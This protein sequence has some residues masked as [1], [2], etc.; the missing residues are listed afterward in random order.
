MTKKSVRLRIEGRVQGVWYRAWTMQTA[1]AAG[2]DGWVE[3]RRDGSVE[4]ALSGPGDV[5]DAMIRDCWQ[6][7]PAARVSN[8]HIEPEGKDIA[9]GFHQRGTF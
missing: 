9:P 2:L 6:G 5:V 3:N 1:H 7:P 4:V 8:I